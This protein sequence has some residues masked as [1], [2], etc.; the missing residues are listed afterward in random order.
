MVSS[1]IDT[2]EETL[3]PAPP[4]PND[5]TD[6][7][8]SERA[9]LTRNPTMADHLAADER[10]ATPHASPPDSRQPELPQSEETET[11]RKPGLWRRILGP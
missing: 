8:P 3:P 10:R 4:A 5:Q 9:F 6:E 7:R 2:Q 1:L 11:E